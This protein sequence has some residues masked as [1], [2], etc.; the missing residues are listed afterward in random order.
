MVTETWSQ[1]RAV[2]DVEG[3]AV[4][5]VVRGVDGVGRADV[6]HALLLRILRERIQLQHGL[7]EHEGFH[8]LLLP[9]RLQLTAMPCTSLLNMDI[10]S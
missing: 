1:Q 4:P 2:S 6:V 5:G 10:G 3:A 9:Q 8:G 7:V